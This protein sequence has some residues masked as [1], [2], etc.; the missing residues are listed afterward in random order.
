MSICWVSRCLQKLLATTT[1]THVNSLICCVSTFLSALVNK[2]VPISTNVLSF[3]LVACTI[4]ILWHCMW[5]LYLKPVLQMCQ[6]L[7]LG[8][9][10]RECHKLRSSVMFQIVAL[11]TDNSRGVI[12]NHNVFILQ[13]I[14]ACHFVYNNFIYRHLV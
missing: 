8:L 5:W 7:G 10:L 6:S 13:A 11:H 12:Y 14:G 1:R 2:Q 9:S 3:Y 4:K